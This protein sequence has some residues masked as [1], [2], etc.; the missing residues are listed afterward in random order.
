MFSFGDSYATGWPFWVIAAPTVF[1]S[2]DVSVV[3]LNSPSWPGKASHG[4]DVK[5]YFNSSIAICIAYVYLID[6]GFVDIILCVMFV[7]GSGMIEK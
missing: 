3:T 4:A 5:A 7:K 2:S 6:L 1:A